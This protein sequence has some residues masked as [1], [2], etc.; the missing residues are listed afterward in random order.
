MFKISKGKNR[1]VT[2]I[3]KSLVMWYHPSKKGQLEKMIPL[4]EEASMII[5]R[6]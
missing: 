5:V 1:K 6:S 4:G 2:L 3:L